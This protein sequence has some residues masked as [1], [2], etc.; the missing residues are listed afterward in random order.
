MVVLASCAV[1]VLIAEAAVRLTGIEREWHPPSKTAV[2]LFYDDPN[3]PEYLT[4]NWQGY[5]SEE[6]TQINA[7]GFRDVSHAP[8]ATPGAFRFAVVGDSY[9]M[10]DG[11]RLEDTYVKQLETM[12]SRGRPAEGLNCGVT[13]SNTLNQAA[14]LPRM[15]QH[16][17]PAL[18]ITA[19]N[20]ND[21]EVYTETRFDRATR[22]GRHFTVNN[23][24]T[25]TLESDDGAAA[26][27]KTWFREHSALYRLGAEFLPL[28][29]G[30]RSDVVGKVHHAFQSGEYERSI[31]ALVQMRDLAESNHAQFLVALIPGLLDTP[32]SV[33]NMKEYPFS[34][35][36]RRICERLASLGVRCVDLAGAFGDRNPND[37]IVHRTNRHYNAEG[38][39]LIAQALDDYLE[40]HAAELLRVPGIVPSSAKVAT[41]SAH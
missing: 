20:V 23:D 25:V 1:A 6:W 16:Y 34:E 35:E 18:V 30:A 41:A 17:R 21:F 4:P 9:T 10:G 2:L 15:L 29:T 14:A 39:R 11:V 12:L 37:L 26:A 13:S 32:P 28:L 7:D 40:S 27:V 38:H 22:D 31:E 5:V 19:Y 3:G 24:G 33:T 8:Y 36:H